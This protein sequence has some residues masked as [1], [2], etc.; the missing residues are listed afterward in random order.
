MDEETVLQKIAAHEEAIAKHSESGQ[1]GEAAAACE[2]ALS[3]RV[4][5]FGLADPSLPGLAETLTR[6]SNHAAR[7]ELKEGAHL[8][9]AEVR[10]RRTLALLAE[11]GSGVRRRSLAPCFCLTLNNL[12]A[13]HQELGRAVVALACLREA[14]SFS[15]LLPY[16]DA[17]ATHMSLCTVLS[18]TGRHAEAEGSAAE[19]VRLAELDILNL[20]SL[21][22]HDSKAGAGMLQEKVSTL[23]VAYN[24]LA[25]Q[26]EHLGQVRECLA[27]YEKAVVLAQGHM[28]SGSSLL[29]RLKESYVKAMQTTLA[30]SSA[31]EYL[32]NAAP[33]GPSR[34]TALDAQGKRRPASAGNSCRRLGALHQQAAKQV[35]SAKALH[36]ELTMLLRGSFDETRKTRHESDV[37]PEEVT[38]RNTAKP[39]Q[40]ADTPQDE[41]LLLD[42]T[43]ASGSAAA[44]GHP[45][46]ACRARSSSCR[47]SL[48]RRHEVIS[49]ERG[50]DE[51]T[52]AASS[53]SSS[54]KKESGQP[55]TAALSIGTERRLRRIF[56]QCSVGGSCLNKHT[57]IKICRRSPEVARFFRLPQQL[58]QQ[59]DEVTSDLVERVFC[60]L[61]MSSVTGDGEITWGEFRS[62]FLNRIASL[63]GPARYRSGSGPQRALLQARQEDAAMRMEEAIADETSQVCC[64]ETLPRLASSPRVLPLQAEALQRVRSQ[65]H[66]QVGLKVKGGALVLEAEPDA[67]LPPTSADLQVVGKDEAALLRAITT[68]AALEEDGPEGYS[69]DAFENSTEQD[70]CAGTMSGTALSSILEVEAPAPA[71]PPDRAVAEVTKDNDELAVA[72][73]GP[74]EVQ[75][76]AEEKPFEVESRSDDVEVAPSRA[77]VL[78]EA[79]AVARETAET[80]PAAS[81]SQPSA[82]YAVEQADVDIQAS[83]LKEAAHEKATTEEDANEPTAVT[84]AEPADA[85]DL[86]LPEQKPCETEG[87]DDG[88]E[89]VPSSVPVGEPATTS[90]AAVETLESPSPASS[91]QLR[92]IDTAEQ[93]SPSIHA[94]VAAPDL[95]APAA[96]TEDAEEVVA[97][98]DEP[99]K[100]QDLT[101][102]S[103][104]EVGSG[105][106]DVEA[107]PS[108]GRAPVG[109]PAESSIVATETVETS[110]LATS[111][112]PPPTSPAAHSGVSEAD[113]AA[114]TVS[115]EAEVT[116]AVRSPR[117][118]VAPAEVWWQCRR[119][120][121]CNEVSPDWCVLCDAPRPEGMPSKSMAPS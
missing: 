62:F 49:G 19:A 121:F 85:Q 65:A 108:S 112:Q 56:D 4:K 82:N 24:N 6:L 2:A 111:P 89:A 15:A 1:S 81:S 21:N 28:E 39:Q 9:A 43:V 88:V 17:A 14:A 77:P 74:A 18:Q 3:L 66:T 23:A 80:L 71:N 114:P 48:S 11:V 104:P 54:S 116:E 76:L 47:L 50:V 84:S 25:V 79:S 34:R 33:L 35:L 67:E 44:A 97:V 60:G 57:L 59:D 45:S 106:K 5:A 8:Q 58:C 70:I 30:R 27:L 53:S 92:A 68:P 37:N 69:A 102:E 10:L 107:Q 101:K 94:A 20:P 36:E 29:R 52:A 75:D 117:D 51:P 78:G 73:A 13:V 31:Q 46:K 113:L 16:S 109:E 96:A 120:S 40:S 105:S 98:L 7:A 64:L 38:P 110:G 42:T 119:C 100:A 55:P 95:A 115:T 12:A 22:S 72:S 26:K 90:I 32:E 93:A 63:G 41:T 99:A 103:S 87:G 118:D 83:A 86:A 61:G 91:P